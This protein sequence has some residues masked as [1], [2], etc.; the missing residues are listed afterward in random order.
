MWKWLIGLAISLIM[1]QVF[2]A[3]FLVVLRRYLQKTEE[4]FKRLSRTK[5]LLAFLGIS[6]FPP[7]DD[8]SERNVPLWIVGPLERLFFTLIIA[9][10]IPGFPIAMVGWITLKMLGSRPY[11]KIEAN[12]Q[13][14]TAL[15]FEFA[16]LLGNLLSM[17]FALIGGMIILNFDC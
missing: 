1:G 2:T 16:G 13:G 15:S 17:L 14:A 8:P 10:D 3:S 6:F 5:K 7:L 4:E 11:R 12:S 9:W